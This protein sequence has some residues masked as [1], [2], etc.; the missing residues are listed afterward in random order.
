MSTKNLLLTLVSAFGGGRVVTTPALRVVL[1]LLANGTLMGQ[2][3]PFDSGSTGV[4]GAFRARVPFT[5]AR[6]AYA[7]ASDP[8]RNQLVLFGGYGAGRQLDDTWIWDGT[9]WILQKPGV[10]PPARNGSAMAYEAARQQ[11]VLFGGANSSGR[12]SDTWIWNGT[13]WNSRTPSKSPTGR[14]A[15]GLVYDSARRE[16]V[17]F[18]GFTFPPRIYFNDTWVWDGTSWLPRTPAHSPSKRQE[19]AMAYDAARGE[20]VLFGGRDDGEIQLADTWV[21]NGVDWTERTPPDKSPTPRTGH[22]M[23]YDAARQVVVLFGGNSGLQAVNDTW[24]WDG[25]SWAIATNA[26]PPTARYFGSLAFDKLRNQVVLAGGTYGIEL[27]DTWLWSGSAWTNWNGVQYFDLGARSDGAWNFTTV[28][29]AN[30]A[31]VVFRKSRSNRPVRWLAS[32]KVT[33]DGIVDVSGEDGTVGGFAVPPP[34]GGPGGFDGGLGGLPYFPGGSYAGA[35]GQGQGGGRPGMNGGEAGEPGTYAS[36]YGNP[37]IVPLV[38]GSGGGGRGSAV[39]TYGNNG[40]GGGGAILIASSRDIVISG[41][42]VA[43]GGK[44]SELSGAGSGGAIRL[45]ADRI[46]LTNSAVLQ[47][48]SDGRIRLESYERRLLGTIS[49]NSISNLVV[50]SPV[51]EPTVNIDDNALQII[52]VAGNNVVQPPGGN[53]LAPDVTFSQPGDITVTVQAQ[54]IP[55]GTP[56]RLRVTMVGNEINKPGPGEP[57]VLLSGGKAT[58]SITVPP[59]RGTLQAFAEFA[60]Q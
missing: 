14:S 24:L 17:L 48:A 25:T 46:I 15:F 10:R 51:A 18:G 1:W 22:G 47:A 43:N 23:T 28:D 30:G 44:P 8:D 19:F 49:P 12:L 31:H 59:G 16:V 53:I 52:A 21:W 33:I 32:G 35:P 27:G 36:T 34:A 4:D 57:S 60:L 6:Y 55:D 20:V 38:G 2:D 11:V 5:P 3:L 42:I 54:N 39:G 40:G 29:V 9:D 41:T 7:V 26:S 58:F 50:S 45:R 56:V 37:F 13:N